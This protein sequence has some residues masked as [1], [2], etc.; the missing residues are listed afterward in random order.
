MSCSLRSDDAVVLPLGEE[1]EVRLEVDVARRERLAGGDTDAVE[2]I[3]VSHVEQRRE[4][5]EPH[6][7]PARLLERGAHE[8]G[9]VQVLAAAS[10]IVKS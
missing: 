7:I 3:A 5:G 2:K 4:S 1:V 6:L 8:L 9:A 10:S